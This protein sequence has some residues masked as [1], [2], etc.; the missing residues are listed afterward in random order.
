MLESSFEWAQT[1][2][3]CKLMLKSWK[4]LTT[5]SKIV[6]PIFKLSWDTPSGKTCPFFFLASVNNF[7]TQQRKSLLAVE[8]TC[9]CCRN[10]CLEIVVYNTQVLFLPLVLR[11]IIVTSQ[12]VPQSMFCC[13]QCVRTTVCLQADHWTTIAKTVCTK[14]VVLQEAVET[15][16]LSWPAYLVFFHLQSLA[17]NLCCS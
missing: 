4:I 2:S 16:K 10:C 12:N 1:T 15:G 17:S 3:N 7:E 8:V 14:V 11:R 5:E 13:S 9:S 6:I